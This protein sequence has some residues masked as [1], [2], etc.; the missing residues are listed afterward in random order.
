MDRVLTVKHTADR[1]GRPLACIARLPGDGAE[2]S[3]T[4]LRQLARAF[5][6]IADECEQGAGLGYPETLHYDLAD[7]AQPNPCTDYRAQIC[8][9]YSTAQRL[10]ALV[11]HLYNGAAHPVRLDNLLANADERHTDIALALIKHYAA[12]G[13]NCPEFMALARHLVERDQ[14]AAERAAAEADAD[15]DE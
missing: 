2:F 15:A 14:A 6:A 9:G 1:R 8:G 5:N 3:A 11:K 13:E 10:A 4:Q 7:A 12:H